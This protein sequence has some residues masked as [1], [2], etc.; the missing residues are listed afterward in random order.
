MTAATT[1]ANGGGLS[2]TPS[3]AAITLVR[4]VRPPTARDRLRGSGCDCPHCT[5]HGHASSLVK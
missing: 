2:S 3:F 5:L 1:A 4:R